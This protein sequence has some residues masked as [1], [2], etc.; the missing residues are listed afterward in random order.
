MEM[1]ATGVSQTQSLTAWVAGPGA[2][3]FLQLDSG[4]HGVHRCFV[5]PF[6]A[7]SCTFHLRIS[8]AQDTKIASE[9][10][11]KLLQVAE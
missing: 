9:C 6:E 8:F 11:I 1:V 2:L 10:A 4:S 3:I 5:A 7:A